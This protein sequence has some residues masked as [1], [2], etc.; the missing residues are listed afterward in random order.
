M[1]D[2]RALA[3]ISSPAG[4]I[5]AGRL[6]G[7]DAAVLLVQAKRGEQS[8]IQYA[9][10]AC[11]P[12]LLLATG[13]QAAQP[14]KPLPA[15]ELAQLAR[16]LRET[17]AREN[18]RLRTPAESAMRLSLA[19]FRGAEGSEDLARRVNRALVEGLS[20][21][22]TLHPDL[23]ILE[24][25]RLEQLAWEKEVGDLSPAPFWSARHVI[26]G[27]IEAHA[28]DAE[29]VSVRV[30]IETPA[31]KVG[32]EETFS[33]KLGEPASLVAPIAEW[34]GRT[35]KL[36][37]PPAG[38]D[39]KVEARRIGKAAR[40]AAQLWSDWRFVDGLAGSAWV[41]GDQGPEQL[42]LRIHSL[43]WRAATFRPR[44]RIYG[45]TISFDNDTWSRLAAAMAADPGEAASRLEFVDEAVELALR[46]ETDLL[47]AD[48]A[49]RSGRQAAA[50]LVR[51]ASQYLDALAAHPAAWKPRADAVRR[52]QAGVVKLHQRAL[53]NHVIRDDQDG[54]RLLFETGVEFTPSW[55]NDSESIAA[56]YGKALARPR[57]DFAF[58]GFS[59]SHAR[60]KLREGLLFDPVEKRF[61]PRFADAAPE[62]MR[63]A[64][65]DL[66]LNLAASE[67]FDDRA[68]AW[69]AEAEAADARPDAAACERLLADRIPDFVSDRES[70]ILLD[71]M[72]DVMRAADPERHL[73][74]CAAALP[75]AIRAYVKTPQG[76]WRRALRGSFWKNHERFTDAELAEIQLAVEEAA[77]INADGEI[78]RLQ[79][80]LQALRPGSKVAASPALPPQ[81]AQ[82][83]APRRIP[84]GPGT[85]VLMTDHMNQLGRQYHQEGGRLWAFA[86]PAS[87]I[88]A[89]EPPRGI[90]ERIALPK[91]ADPGERVLLA[92]LR[93]SAVSDRWIVLTAPGLQVPWRFLIYDRSKRE[94]RRS[95]PAPPVLG[96]PLLLGDRLAAILFDPYGDISNRG[97]FTYSIASGEVT[98]QAHARGRLAADSPEL[99]KISPARLVRA[100][101][102]RVLLRGTPEPLWWDTA[103][104]AIHPP[105]P[106]E[107]VL[108]PMPLEEA[109][110]IGMD[111]FEVAW[112][113]RST[114]SE[115]GGIWW[116][117]REHQQR[118]FLATTAPEGERR[119]PDVVAVMP[120]AWFSVIISSRTRSLGSRGP[121]S[122]RACANSLRNGPANL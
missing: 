93:I 107:P 60:W 20:S 109:C 115:R 7:A 24:R 67:A 12:G 13:A 43:T 22:L 33:G 86:Y 105:P 15:S 10:A 68:V 35:L 26:S 100:E 85:P 97:L 11:G 45:P 46:R 58:R 37:A 9:V 19:E 23:F 76:P 98:V 72:L 65:A 75:K 122:K 4:G 81:L 53:G 5:A 32:A 99:P 16:A 42:D 48:G 51:F 29:A 18:Q 41:L 55:F 30:R 77:A 3:A 116:F 119:V 21:E 102:D 96:H 54:L 114:N 44:I 94:W 111:A 82:P 71:R 57:S 34:L 31:G 66:L 78:S 79:Q 90:V 25:L 84:L 87:A 8:V 92:S 2:E 36:S 108:P 1:L 17:L 61:A 101:G 64:R 50:L 47:G 14:E 56:A 40:Q 70:S 62:R 88:V 73:R 118:F 38:M 74:F 39:P 69:L 106:G 121:R 63:R 110:T 117:S 103:T 28:T 95:A 80:A 120:G 83:L 52:V 91:A 49:R 104:G 89:I 59:L 6:V 113:G 112:L 27:I